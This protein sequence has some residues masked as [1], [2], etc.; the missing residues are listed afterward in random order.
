MQSNPFDSPEPSPRTVGHFPLPLRRIIS[1]KSR[2]ATRPTA[3]K[4]SDRDRVVFSNFPDPPA[5][6]G[7]FHRSSPVSISVCPSCSRPRNEWPGSRRRAAIVDVSPDRL[8]RSISIFTSPTARP[9]TKTIATNPLSPPQHR[10]PRLPSSFCRPFVR[11]PP[12]DIPRRRANFRIFAYSERPHLHV[13]FPCLRVSRISTM[14][15]PCTEFH[16]PTI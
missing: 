7:R 16:P 15:W 4:V 10:R 9:H 1:H 14:R 8:G 5:R 6:L 11:G 12:R 3:L 13:G 2:P